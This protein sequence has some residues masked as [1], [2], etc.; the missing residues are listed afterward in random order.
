MHKFIK[1]F[2]YTMAALLL[3]LILL[4]GGLYLYSSSISIAP[5]ET[6]SSKWQQQAIRQNGNTRMLGNNWLHKNSEGLYEMYIEGSAFDRGVAMGKLS[7][8]LI[9]YQ[10]QAFVEQLQVMIPSPGYMKFLKNFIALFNKNLDE[11][12]PL[13][14]QQEIYGVSQ[15]A[16]SAFDFI[17]PAYSRMLNY[18]AAHDIGHAMQ[19]MNL[20]AC[21]SFGVWNNR[22]QDSTLT[23]GRNFD[24]YVGDAFAQNKIVLFVRPEQGIPFVIITWGGMTGAVSG[25]NAEGLTLTL[26]AA[27]SE[28][29]T[30]A[31]TPIS[32]IARE[33]L[34]YASTID[35][36]LAIAKKR[37]SFVAESMLI[38]SAKDNRA[39]LI[40][41]TPKTTLLYET[42]T[43]GQLISTNHF[44]S[45]SLK[46]EEIVQAPI[47]DY[48]TTYRYARMEELLA[49][50]TAI[51]PEEA[52]EI[53]RNKEGLE[54]N[55][56]GL[57]N[58]KAV[59][60]LIAHHGIIFQPQKRKFWIATAPYQLGTFIGYS[61]DSIFNKQRPHFPVHLPA[62]TLASD[63]FLQQ[64]YND[65]LAYKHAR[66]TV[67]AYLKAENPNG[68]AL[69]DSILADLT[70]KNPSFYLGY[71][72][73]GDYYRNRDVAKAIACYKEA[74]AC[75]LPSAGT[76]EHIQQELNTLK[77]TQ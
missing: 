77:K 71:K 48:A 61:L 29:P 42:K 20:V 27:K 57:G 7:D 43:P 18:H 14:F 51:G 22:A 8:S 9:R 30:S 44:Q 2:L 55:P 65:F 70:E 28:I 53:L 34:Q 67:Q 10:E 17:A 50:Y 69:P 35:E 13:E 49:K 75:E 62:D 4:I 52:A 33:V 21:T 54:N 19:N 45:D 73:L 3:T 66:N 56:I 60:Q 11:Y 31:A 37:K 39:A 41:K 76:R 6:N 64:G 58:E 63:A 46:R 16:D 32:L 23:I 25:M 5:P 15:A 47:E 72:L 68:E 26:N 12:I 74:L 24:F 1:I 38:G 40:E 59:N 36:A